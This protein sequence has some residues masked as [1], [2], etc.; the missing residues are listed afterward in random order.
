[1]DNNVIMEP[2]KSDINSID[3]DQMFASFRS[4]IV[5]DQQL[6]EVRCSD[7]YLNWQKIVDIANLIIFKYR[8]LVECELV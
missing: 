2:N 8:S 5:D 6:R 4:E 1:M 3:L 7:R